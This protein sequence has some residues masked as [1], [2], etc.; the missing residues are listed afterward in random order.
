M[1][2]GLK[3]EVPEI[4]DRLKERARTALAEL[5]DAVSNKDDT[6]AEMVIEEKPIEPLVL[7]AAMPTPRQIAV[8]DRLLVRL[9]RMIDPLLAYSVGKSV[10]AVWRRK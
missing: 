8:W 2:E 4:P 6:I 7:K 3:Y 1:N 10:V 9:S 5:I